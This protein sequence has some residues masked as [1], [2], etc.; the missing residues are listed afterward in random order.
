MPSIRPRA[1]RLANGSLVSYD[2]LVVA[3]GA[4]HSYFGHDEWAPLAPGLKTLSDAFEI[5]RRV[6]MSYEAAE[7]ATDPERRRACSPSW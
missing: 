3:A 4:A 7:T 6:L 1:L 5:R 2:H